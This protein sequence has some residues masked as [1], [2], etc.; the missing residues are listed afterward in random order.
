MQEAR[1]AVGGVGA[2]LGVQGLP[3]AAAMLFPSDIFLKVS[4]RLMFPGCCS[5]NAFTS[6][7]LLII[8]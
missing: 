1:P 4:A 2:W 5:Q 7:D 6:R 3:G 8:L